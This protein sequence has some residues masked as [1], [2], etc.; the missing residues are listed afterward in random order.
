[1]ITEELT[2]EDREEWMSE[3]DWNWYLVDYADGT[4]EL[5]HATGL[6][7]ILQCGHDPSEYDVIR[8]EQCGV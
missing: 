5:V 4:T 2:Q 8:M 6:S 1:V 3:N 7:N